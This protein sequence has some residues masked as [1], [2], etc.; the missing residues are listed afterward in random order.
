MSVAREPDGCADER[1]AGEIGE[2]LELWEG[3]LME[4]PAGQAGGEHRCTG[5]VDDDVRDG[6]V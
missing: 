3:Q 1:V 5:G 2:R 6:P 4:G